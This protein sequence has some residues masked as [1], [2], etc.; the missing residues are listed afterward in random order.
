MCEVQKCQVLA[1]ARATPQE[2]RRFELRHVRTVR[3]FHEVRAFRNG[4]DDAERYEP[5]IR[6]VVGGHR[7]SAIPLDEVRG[8]RPEALDLSVPL[9]VV[10]QAAC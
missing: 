1:D 6:G 4:S 10:V 5:T 8:L 3:D 2:R 9:R 7:S